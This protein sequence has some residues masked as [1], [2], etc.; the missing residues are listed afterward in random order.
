MRVARLAYA[1]AKQTF[2]LYSH[3]KSP[4]KF[5]QPQ[6]VACVLLM[7]YLKLSYRDVEDGL[8]ATDQVCQ[9]LELKPIPD[10]STLAYANQR[11]LKMSRLN[12]LNR[13]LLDQ[14]DV[15]EEAVA[16]DTTGFPTTQASRYYR[17]RSGLRLREYPKGAYA[18]GTRSLFILAWRQGKGPGHD[19]VF[20]GG[21][22]RDARRSTPPR[23][24]VM[25]GDAGFDG[26]DVRPSDLIPPIRRGGNLVDPDRRASAD[27]V[28][29]ARLEGLFGQR[30]KAETVISVIKPKFSD[31]IR[32]RLRS[33]QPRE[34]IIKGLIYNIHV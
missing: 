27:L 29:A 1:L 26:K 28:S 34:P 25:L 5:T 23:C 31:A 32:A 16:S 19:R 20:L 18:V 17:S 30:W 33:L 8:L 9:V 13:K 3:P 12:D 21:L 24:W 22:R 10:Y 2:P 7:Y 15:E 6:W 4:H 14:A 11:L